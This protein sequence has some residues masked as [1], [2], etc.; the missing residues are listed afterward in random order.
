[1]ALYV[2]LIDADT[3]PLRAK[4]QFA[5]I[6]PAGERVNVKAIGDWKE[7][8]QLNPD[9]SGPSWG[10]PR[11]M[12]RSELV[13]ESNGFM[14]NDTVTFE[15]KLTVLGT[16]QHNSLLDSARKFEQNMLKANAELLD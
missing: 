5:I 11:F 3:N 6:N 2:Q 1:M 8:G 13:D 12:L 14:L 9:R 4:Y 7:F 16:A 15:V 10:F